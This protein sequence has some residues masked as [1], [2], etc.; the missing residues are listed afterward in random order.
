MV[1]W[2]GGREGSDLPLPHGATA[3]RFNYSSVPAAELAASTGRG[4]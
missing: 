2:V 1:V 3:N 4:S